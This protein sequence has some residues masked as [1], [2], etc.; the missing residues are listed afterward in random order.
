[1][2]KIIIISILLLGSLKSQGNDL[3]KALDTHI[4]IQD[5]II[6]IL[7][8]RN[9]NKDKLIEGLKSVIALEREKQQIYQHN[10][11]ALRANIITQEKKFKAEKRGVGIITGASGMALGIL[12]GI[13]VIK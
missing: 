12:I 4:E 6:R 10:L 9:S 13:I 11:T 5:S 7:E 1:M 8:V 3:I 2:N